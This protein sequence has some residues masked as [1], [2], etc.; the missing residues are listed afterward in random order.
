MGKEKRKEREV[1]RCGMITVFCLFV[2]LF[3]HWLLA[4]IEHEMKLSFSGSGTLFST[5][6]GVDQ[7]ITAAR[8][9]RMRERGRVSV[10]EREREREREREKEREREGEGEEERGK[11]RER[12]GG[13]A[14]RKINLQWGK[15]DPSGLCKAI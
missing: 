6:D 1:D 2:C 8:A 5:N 4:Y 9:V 12:E 10:C 13:G 15:R 7:I 14:E 11:E 3:V